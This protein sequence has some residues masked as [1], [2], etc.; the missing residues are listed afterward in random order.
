MNKKNIFLGIA[1]VYLTTNTIYAIQLIREH[2]YKSKVVQERK[3]QYEL[4]MLAIANAEAKMRRRAE[5]GEFVDLASYELEEV[6]NETLKF[7]QIA[8]REDV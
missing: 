7:E 6:W 4:D 1:L 5:L 2:N 3:H 8:V